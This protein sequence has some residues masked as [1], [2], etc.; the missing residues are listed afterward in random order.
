MSSE[1]RSGLADCLLESVTYKSPHALSEFRQIEHAAF[2]VNAPDVDE[3]ILFNTNA[4]ILDKKRFSVIP[5]AI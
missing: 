1:I 2:T 5:S 4:Y 3:A